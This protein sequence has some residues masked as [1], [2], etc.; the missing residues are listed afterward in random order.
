MR[1]IQLLLLVSLLLSVFTY[2]QNV[3]IEPTISPDFFAA[4]ETITITYD[5]TGT[6]LSSL[7]NAWLWLW[8][9]D[10][11]NVNVS[12]NVNP[13]SSDPSKSDKAKFTKTVEAGR[14]LFK[15]SLKLTDFTGK[16]ASEIH[17]VGV[18]IKGNDW[19]NGQ[20]KD[21]PFDILTGFATKIS[22]PSKAFGFYQ[23]GQTIKFDV[24]ISQRS[25]IEFS[26]DGEVVYTH[27]D[28]NKF[29]LEHAVIDDG[30]V[31][32]LHFQA[33]HG[34][35][36]ATFHHSYTTPPV[37][38]EQSL[39]SG[40]LN[41]VNHDSDHSVTLVLTA[42]NK[43]NVFVIGDFN[44]WSLDEDFLMKKDGNKFWLE[45]PNLTPNTE[46]IYQY[47]IDG[48]LI[49]AD[50]Y[51]EKVSSVYDDS[52]IISL[53]RYPG[54]KD[55]PSDKTTR[56]ASYL[57]VGM[58]DYNWTVTDF[59]KPA[60][61]DLVI[62]E[63][64]VRDFTEDRSYRAVIERLDYLDSLGINALELMPVTE[65][66]GNL[67]WGYNPS[68]MLA[69]DKYYGTEDELKE[70]IDEC[71]KRGIA[72]IFDMVLNHQFGRSP[73]VYMYS[74]GE[75]GPPTSQ[76]PWFNVTAKHDYNVGYD[77]N[78][79][80][81]YTKEFVSRVVTYWT[82]NFKVDGYR[83]DLSKGFT[84]KNTLGNVD[85]WGKKD[86]TRIAIW[87]NIAD[88]IWAQNPETYIILEHFAENSEEKELANYGMMLWGNVNSMYIQAAKGSSTDLGWSYYDLRGWD[89]PNL[90]A[91][92]ESHDEERVMWSLGGKSSSKLESYIARLKLNA[93]FF[94]LTPGPKMIWQF[95]ELAYD[96]ELNN[97]RV[98]IKPTHWEYLEDENR[99][100]LY[101]TY[102][103]LANLKTQTELLDAS[104]FS[105]GVSTSYKW[106]NYDNDG[107]KICAFGNFGSSVASGNPHILSE[108]TWYD[109]LT[110]EEFQVTNTSELALA[111]GE[112]HI[113]TSSPIEN[114]IHKSPV[115]FV[116]SAPVKKSFNLFPVPANDFINIQSDAK[117]LGITIHDMSG[118][119]LMNF[120]AH[121]LESGKI[122]VSNLPKGLYL[123]EIS[124]NQGIQHKK[125]I[126][127]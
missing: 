47:L 26:V 46:Y 37:V 112:F 121:T 12:S 69:T 66:E 56:E 17:K 16:S 48:Q 88:V 6:S 76:N 13:A 44:D 93:A 103:A 60:K 117:I 9:P 65:Y 62:Y 72:V 99:A 4:D 86:D 23:T 51:S 67:S 64:L 70:L 101:A 15:I 21:H 18:L 116:T 40:K 24:A 100:S 57:R 20:S 68:Y 34:E 82:E 125:V 77:L 41:G 3:N 30:K 33:T 110:G 29:Y 80:S 10:Q 113:L 106:L 84:Q 32:Q 74:S 52:E 31:H 95:G 119:V 59:E 8:L 115:N 43:S 90:V 97:D 79:E 45:I 126:K 96:E 108:G 35:D 89:Q 27:A 102:Q 25:A 22:S 111:S 14:T 19:S 107:I 54:L 5:V 11:T 49:M 104:K 50:P 39:P 61:E 98:G 73:M 1:K 124:T 105:W 94:F 109:Y 75:F 81:E 83:F 55:Y 2:G 123:F 91:Y 92:M 58:P 85:A 127:E 7:S 120:D 36:M 118:R 71:H 42:P 122:N 38:V 78:H 114:Y 63:L 53:N 87:K 28:T